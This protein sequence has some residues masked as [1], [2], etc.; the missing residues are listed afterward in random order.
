MQYLKH[1]ILL[2]LVALT[3]VGE[4]A[5]II[6]WT[7]N[8]ITPSGENIRF[9]LTVDY[10]IAVAS[11]AVF[12]ALNLVALLLIIRKNKIGPLLLIAFSIIN[13]LI[14]EPIFVGG[15]HLIFVTWTAQ[16]V[17]F[18][19]LEYRG[20]SNRGTLFLSGGVI[21]DLIVTSLLFSP[22]DSLTFGVVF[23][24]VFLAVWVGLVATIKKLR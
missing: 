10:R 12:G 9:T 23:Y 8:P 22:A 5:S 7:A 18:A 4:V 21:L 24:S 13:R 11:A 16:L 20:L 14:S 2:V 19:Y 6:L 1:K 17:I 3:I 15:I